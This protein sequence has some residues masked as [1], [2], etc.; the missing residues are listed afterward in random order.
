MKK[1]LFLLLFVTT[2]S[3]AFAQSEPAVYATVIKKFALFYNNNKPDSIYKIFGPEMRNALN[4]EQFRAT[5]G[6][7]KAQLGPLNNTAF[8]NFKNPVASYTGT[9][10][11]GALVIRLSLNAQNEIIGLLLQPAETE[12]IASTLT[13]D[14]ALTET[15]VTQKT[16]SGNISGTLTMPKNAHGP[17]PVVLIIAGSGPTDRDGN[18]P[19][20]GLNG[21]TYKLLANALGDHGIAS[22]RYDKRLVGKSV[23]KTKEK[24]LRFEDYS[25]DAIALVN[26][27]HDDNRFSKIIVLGHSEGSLVGML[28]SADQPVNAFI[29]VAGAGDRADIILT[30]QM[31]SQPQYIANGFKTI[32]DSLKRGKFTDV[33][34]PALY[35]IA[36]PSVQPYLLSWMMHDPAREIKKLKIPVLI[37]QGTTDLQVGVADAE[38]LKKADKNAVLDIIPGMNHVLKAAPVDRDK[39]LATYRDPDLPLKPELVTAIVSFID[40]LK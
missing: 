12:A 33:V 21:Y 6:Q 8:I 13:D 11:N 3:G 20:L 24:E 29:S 16:L 22:L 31:K 5:M 39:N 38:K 30:E 7:L 36:R 37:I 23:S 15:P 2:A 25:D 27:L 35:P 9:F 32:M 26:M 19:K 28:A 14:P 40:K 10:Q 1:L 4:A 17:I 18:S 34:D